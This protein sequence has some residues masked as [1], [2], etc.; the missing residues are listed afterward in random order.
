MVAQ[1]IAL[2]VLALIFVLG[3][4]KPIHL[5]VLALAAAFGVGI[6]LGGETTKDIMGGFPVAILVLLLGVTYLFAIARDA[7]VVDWIIGRALT[8][9]RG[10][11]VLLPWIFFALA[12]LLGSMGSPLTALAL[13]PVAMVFAGRHSLD[14]VLMGLS[15]TLGGAA[16]GFAP[17]SLFGLITN[18]VA[19]ESGITADPLL[20]FGAG[21]GF[22][23]M[24]MI[25]AFF[26]FG[27]R[28]LIGARFSDDAPTGAKRSDTAPGSVVSTEG[29]SG[30]GRSEGPAGV[31]TAVAEPEL[32]VEQASR[33]RL[34]A[35]QLLSLSSLLGLI[36][37]VIT[38]SA[39]GVA[40]DVGVIALALAVMVSLVSPT[41]TRS[42]IKHVDWSTILLVGGIVTY[43]GVLERMGAIEML[44][45][46]AESVSSPLLA[47]FVI[48]LVGAAVSAFASTTG[49]LG[50]LIPLAL[51]LMASGNFVGYGLIV[52]LAISSNLVDTT[53]FS[54]AGATAVA[55]APEEA[56]PRMTRV[57]IRW[58]FSMILIGPIATVAIL[59]LPSLA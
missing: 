17:T 52:A 44:G 20:L 34:S 13:V 23:L 45:Q 9:I 33:T 41:R 24:L 4:W 16:G 53:P 28:Q 3:T 30:T 39:L 10:R 56:R 58:G 25:A 50:A 43:V 51:P 8:L 40:V 32:A 49:I 27:G 59:V 6:F 55:S 18:G 46:A 1:I 48:C 14:P 26:L 36:V 15:V 22:N 11:I 2:A 19:G 42:A 12:I 35:F 21:I 57:L 7:G 47:A 31:T 29:L 5:G 54:T 38:L 37:L